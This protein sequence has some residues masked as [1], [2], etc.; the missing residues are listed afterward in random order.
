MQHGLYLGYWAKED[1]EPK[2]D[3]KKEELSKTY[4]VIAFSEESLLWPYLRNYESYFNNI[5]NK[6]TAKM[7]LI[8]YSEL[9][10]LGCEGGSCNNENTQNKTWIYGKG[11]WSASAYNA[12]FMYGVTSNGNFTANRFW[13]S[14]TSGPLGV[15]PVIEIN[16]SEL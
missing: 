8:T 13:T 6:K 16:K 2:N 5:L 15:R 4:P 12:S 7:R 1:G 11:Y 3:Y 9:K 14:D 10:E